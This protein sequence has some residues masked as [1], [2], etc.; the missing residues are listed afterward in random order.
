MDDKMRCGEIKNR[1][2]CISLNIVHV[3]CLPSIIFSEGNVSDSSTLSRKS[4]TEPKLTKD[5]FMK[6]LIY[7][8]SSIVQAINISEEFGWQE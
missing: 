4:L 1:F 6:F 8:Y 7:S 3:T 5:R 2:I